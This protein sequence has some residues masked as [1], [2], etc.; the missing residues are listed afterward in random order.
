MAMRKSFVDDNH[1]TLTN[2]TQQQI[3]GMWKTYHNQ[4]NLHKLSP[5]RRGASLAVPY[6]L[7][8]N[9]DI[10]KQRPI[11]PYSKHPLSKILNMVSRSIMFMLKNENVKSFTAFKVQDFVSNVDQVNRFLSHNPDKVVFARS[12]DVKNMYTELPHTVIKDALRWI[13]DLSLKKNR[14]RF[15]TIRKEGRD[16]VRPGRLSTHFRWSDRNQRT[17][18][19]MDVDQIYDVAVFDLENCFYL[20]GGQVYQQTVG[21]PMGSPLSPALAILICAYYEHRFL[22][23]FHTHES[24]HMFPSRYMD[25]LNMFVVLPLEMAHRVTQI[26][27][28]LTGIYHEDM[29]LESEEVEFQF[30]F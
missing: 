30:N 10:M 25:D 26:W 12:G 19:E 13:L 29:E 4:H 27:N 15:F 17:F 2:Y 3:L 16:G 23:T 20:I 1:Y 8:K 14:S 6:L 11:V 5:W 18:V 22:T 28:L 21:I 24:V 9:K 7:P